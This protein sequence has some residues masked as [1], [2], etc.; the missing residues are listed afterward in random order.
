MTYSIAPLNWHAHA[1]FAELVVRTASGAQ[2]KRPLAA[3]QIRH[4]HAGEQHSRKLLRRK[5]NRN[6]ND[7]TENPSLSPPVPEGRPFAHGSD[8]RLAEGD[9]ILTNLDAPLRPLD[10]R[11][12]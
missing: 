7:R 10:F 11:R 3:F 4:A 2:T 6:A 1:A 8:F 5:S 12:R 9:G